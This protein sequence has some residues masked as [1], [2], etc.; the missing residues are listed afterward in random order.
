MSANKIEQLFFTVQP[1]LSH[2]YS[3]FWL[4]IAIFFSLIYSFMALQQAFSSPYIVQDDARQHVFWMRRF[5]DPELFPNDLIADYFQSVAPLGY[6]L[7]YAIPAAIK[8]DPLVTSKILPSILGVITTYYCFALTMQLLPIPF[9]GFVAALLL[10]QNLWMQD[11]LISGTPK[12]FAIPLLLAF[13]Y[14]YL[15]QSLSGTS[16]T[17]LLLGLFYPSF[18]FICSGLLII[19]L[20]QLKASF[21]RYKPR[22]SKGFLFCFIGLS[23]AFLVLLPYVIS[24][25]EFAPTITVAQA[26]HLP[27]FAP[28]GR[29]AFFN[30]RHP[31]DFWIGG[32]RSGLRIAS[33]LIPP[34]TYF[35]VLL[36][37]IL[38]FKQAFP[39]GQ[40]VTAKLRILTDLILVSLVMFGIAHLLLF[41]LHLPSRY[42]QN[43][44]R[45]VMAIAA[46]ISLTIIT[47]FLFKIIFNRLVRTSFYQRLLAKLILFL[48]SM[49]LVIYPHLTNNFVWTQY[50]QGNAVELYEFLQQQPK[51]IMV[52]SLAS[53]ADNLPTFAQRSILVSQEYAIPYHTGYYFPFR[54][55][56]IDL[57]NASYSNDIT[58]VKQFIRQYK[59]DFWLLET[60]SFT[61]E[62]ITSNPWLQQHQTA[63]QN[64]IAFLKQGNIPALQAYQDSCSV[65]KTQQFNL[66]STECILHRFS[67][68]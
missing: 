32:S 58:V 51:D 27:D 52:A 5:L 59:I 60:N 63:A 65:L 34:L 13:L 61:P 56:A 40:K 68:K 67:D 62:Y 41:K 31:F 21:L 20:W 19:K 49:L 23:I 4:A 64:A 16:T 24:T 3:R 48:L 30:D 8:I 35:A 18:V 33:A 44:L 54:Q 9:T 25:S 6:K 47:H 50:V 2:K 45:I 39:L 1:G 43:S 22:L 38:K 37:L 36:P 12:A 17:I 26:R 11:G 28:N 42:T 7:T 14:Y 55:E 66:I 46:S 15:R 10:N 53:E 29:S 57:I